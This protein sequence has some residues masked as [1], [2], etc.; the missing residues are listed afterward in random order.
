MQ[1]SRQGI[2]LLQPCHAACIF[3]FRAQAR[4]SPAISAAP[5]SG[6][7]FKGVP[8]DLDATLKGS[9]NIWFTEEQNLEVT[10]LIDAQVSH[11]FKRRKMF[12]TQE[13][14]E[15][16]PDGSLVVTFRMGQYE[17]IR[18]ILKSWIPNIVIL[19]PFYVNKKSGLKS[20]RRPPLD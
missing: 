14:K 2:P 8:E 15:E 1:A 19:G 9:A 17:A 13:I 20:G 5:L 10:V 6:C 7:V 4:A 12:P 18:N 11:Y 3:P 16:R